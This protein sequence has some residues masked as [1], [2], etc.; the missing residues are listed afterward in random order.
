[1]QAISTMSDLQAGSDYILFVLQ[2]IDT[3]KFV[4][5]YCECSQGT[6]G[7]KWVILFCH[8]QF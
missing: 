3:I 1:M 4:G 2:L 7:R 6:G 5:N 8:R